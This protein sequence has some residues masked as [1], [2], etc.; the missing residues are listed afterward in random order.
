VA[1]TK[2]AKY[3]LTGAGAKDSDPETSAVTPV[4]M[5]GLKDWGGIK[6]RMKWAFI[7]KP[8]L[9]ID[10]PHSHDFD[11]FLCFL[12]CDPANEL[13]FKAEVE[14]SLGKEKEKQV[15]D[16]PTIVCIPMGL[17]HGPINFKTVDKPVLFCHIYT[18]PE[19][20]RKPVSG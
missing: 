1:K 14:L 19:Y 15:I 20:V 4:V 12:G 2:Y 3:I 17:I 5:G 18:S 13:D 10:E 8:V 7:T 6:H 11:E 9:M 16:V